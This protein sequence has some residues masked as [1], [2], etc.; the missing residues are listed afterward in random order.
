[1]SRD[2]KFFTISKFV[3]FMTTKYK[4]ASNAVAYFN[5]SQ[6]YRN[7]FDRICIKPIMIKISQDSRDVY[8]KHEQILKMFDG[9]LVLS[10]SE[11]QSRYLPHQKR[12]LLYLTID[13]EPREYHEFLYYQT[14]VFRSTNQRN[15]Q[16]IRKQ[17]VPMIQTHEEELIPEESESEIQPDDI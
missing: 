5:A 16:I 14:E 17:E 1:M 11:N 2:L 15:I 3:E 13:F 4:G 7:K 9:Q 12:D 6:A 10:F 8:I